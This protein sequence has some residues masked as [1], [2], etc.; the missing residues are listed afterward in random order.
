MV[1]KLTRA[2]DALE[3]VL[4]LTLVFYQARV[5]ELER[6][7]E[8]RDNEVLRTL[9]ASKQTTCK[10]EVVS[11]ANCKSNQP[12]MNKYSSKDRF[13]QLDVPSTNADCTGRSKPNN[14]FSVNN[15]NADIDSHFLVDEDVS[16]NSCKLKNRAQV[17]SKEAVSISN[18]DNPVNGHNTIGLFCSKTGSRNQAG[19]APRVNTE[20]EDLTLVV[21]EITQVQPLPHIR[22][23][24]PFLGRSSITGIFSWVMF[25]Q[26]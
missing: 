18:G 14:V 3:I 17:P 10:S 1:L 22:K 8:E 9:K 21:D 5:Q 23:Q 25:N 12:F 2:F 20:D 24:T 15:A 13:E 4:C 6:D 11:G 26:L 16:K 7:N 19:N